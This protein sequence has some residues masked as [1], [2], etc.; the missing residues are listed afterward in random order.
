MQQVR[1]HFS[2]AYELPLLTRAENYAQV[3]PCP[4]V[5]ALTPSPSTLRMG[6]S[7]RDLGLWRWDTG[8]AGLQGREGWSSE[9]G[10]F[11]YCFC[12]FC[13]GHQNQGGLKS[14]G[15][16]SVPSPGSLEPGGLEARLEWTW[17]S[18]SW[19]R[20]SPWLQLFLTLG[21]SQAL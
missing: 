7:E 16:I 17:H 11:L 18:E 15:T 20:L 21:M 5:L 9:G 4:E 1:T 13:C 12:H 8:L 2:T 14:S 19:D 3:S 6:T 10:F